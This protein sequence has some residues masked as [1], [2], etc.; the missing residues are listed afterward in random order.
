[1]A[2]ATQGNGVYIAKYDISPHTGM[3]DF[4]VIK[5]H[6]YLPGQHVRYIDEFVKDKLLAIVESS[7][8]AVIIDK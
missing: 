2:I 3:V 8:L 5:S 1:L 6:H 4:E 7:G